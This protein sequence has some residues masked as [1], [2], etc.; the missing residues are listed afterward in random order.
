MG[1]RPSR[2]I[3]FE[4]LASADLHVDAVYEAGTAK[5]LGAEPI[6]KMLPVGNA[7]GFRVSGKAPNPNL[8]VLFTSGEEGEWPDHIDPFTGIVRYFGDNRTP[9]KQ[10][11][12]TKNKGNDI[13]RSAFERRHLEADDRITSPI[14][15][16][17]ERG[18]KGLDAV[19]KGLLVPGTDY[20]TSDDDLV[21]IWR[22]KSGSRFQNYR[23][24]FSILNAPTVSKQW[25][26]DVIEGRDRLTNAP[27][28]WRE[29][30]LGSKYLYL[31]AP[32]VNKTR[33]K[34]QQL[35]HSKDKIKLLK[36]LHA[37]FD[38]NP[39][40]FEVVAL[41]IWKMM[42]ANFISAE[43]TRR[44]RDGGRDALGQ[45]FI[46][47]STDP[48]GLDFVLEAKCYDPEKSSVGVKETSRLISRIRH[49]MF[50]VL[51]TTSYVAEQ[52]YKEIR[53]DEHPVVIIS[54]ADIVDVLVEKGITNPAELKAWLDKQT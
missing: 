17:F 52:A 28:A 37:H 49:S 42:A 24:I 41:E 13:L 38:G 34:E 15:L 31:T 27:E 3:P 44:S 45:F 10:L 14:F 51:V 19:F 20:L 22:T 9:G 6:V 4:K 39:F 25:L 43:T 35:P 11:H 53:D 32:K 23:A 50:G 16:L 46:G 21:A 54:G 30:A 40:A 29:W 48:V 2:I 5:N 7:G 18:D 36:T 47:P 26:S 12:E 1:T 8:V 33:S